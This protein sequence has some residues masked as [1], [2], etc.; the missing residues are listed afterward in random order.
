MISETQRRNKF[1]KKI[2]EIS[3]D[4]FVEIER[5]VFSL[6]TNLII[7]DE[8]SSFAGAWKNIDDE[9]FLDLTENLLLRRKL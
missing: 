4:K 2:Q 6:E 3:T 5:F 9:L 7:S 1:A 8:V